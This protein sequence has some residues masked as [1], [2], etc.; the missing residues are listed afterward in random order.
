M[1]NVTL[2]YTHEWKRT[3]GHRSNRSVSIMFPAVFLYPSLFEMKSEV[4]GSDGKQALLKQWWDDVCTFQENLVRHDLSLAHILRHITIDHNTE[5]IRHIKLWPNNTAQWNHVMSRL[6][7]DIAVQI[8]LP[9]LSYSHRQLFNWAAI[10]WNLLTLFL[11]STQIHFSA[12]SVVEITK[13]SGIIWTFLQPV[14]AFWIQQ[15]QIICSGT[16]GYFKAP[17]IIS[18]RLSLSLSFCHCTFTYFYYF[19]SLFSSLLFLLAFF[20]G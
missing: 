14:S 9:T 2:W 7:G 19:T 11:S 4:Q 6:F 17:L 8:C 10:R 5:Q 18:S 15:T 3:G 20:C 1:L 16:M 13:D 12:P